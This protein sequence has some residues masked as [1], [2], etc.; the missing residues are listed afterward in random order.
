[1]SVSFSARAAGTGIAVGAGVLHRG[2]LALRVARL[3][4]TAQHLVRR[5][6]RTRPRCVLCRSCFSFSACGRR[7]SRARARRAST[8]RAARSEATSISAA[9][10]SI[11]RTTALPT[12]SGDDVPIE[13]RRLAAAA[14]E[15]ARVADRPG[16]DERHAD[17]L[18]LH[19][20][21]QHVREPAQAELRRGV[22][23]ALAGRGHLAGERGH[24][25][26]LAAAALDH[27]GREPPREHDRR[28]Q[29]HL[30][31]AVDL[32]LV[33]LQQRARAGQPGV[34][35]QHVDVAGRVGQPLD[36]RAVGEVA[37]HRLGAQLGRQRL[38]APPPGGRSAPAAAPR[39]A[40]AR[41]IASPRPPVA[42][43]SRTRAPSSSIAAASSQRRHRIVARWPKSPGAPPPNTSRT[44]T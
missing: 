18:A 33:E 15:H 36:R 24:E 14:R 6:A 39:S 35:H 44:R 25:H 37:R 32:V 13:R 10:R 29:V 28:A 4:V 9:L 27:R 22:D 19:L 34:G 31:H 11:A 16:R 40:S 20:R 21:A 41:A 7:S 2:D 8:S 1:M 5:R 3:A 17:A 43:V 42:P 23:R 12:S 30:E 38:A 26:E